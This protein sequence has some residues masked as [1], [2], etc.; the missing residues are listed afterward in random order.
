MLLLLGGQFF[1]GSNLSIGDCRVAGLRRLLLD[2]EEH[3]AGACGL[4][5]PA[6]V[7]DDTSY[8]AGVVGMPCGRVVVM[9]LVATLFKS[10]FDYSG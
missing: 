4:S 2:Q 6:T 3:F 1:L 5:E 8:P 7:D 10:V 9:L